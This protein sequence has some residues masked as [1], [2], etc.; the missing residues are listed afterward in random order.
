MADAGEERSPR[1]GAESRGRGARF[2]FLEEDEWPRPHF[3][4]WQ[5][6][7]PPLL[8]CRVPASLRVSVTVTRVLGTVLIGRV[9]VAFVEPQAW[10][11]FAIRHAVHAAAY[12][13][14]AALSVSLTPAQLHPYTPFCLS[15]SGSADNMPP[16]VGTLVQCCQSAAILCMHHSLAPFPPPPAATPSVSD[17]PFQHCQSGLS[18]TE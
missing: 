17:T 6:T 18:P 1:V 9:A 10:E 4:T 8:T 13:W 15:F 3:P 7:W 14:R 5:V 12:A 16:P 11:P 2:P